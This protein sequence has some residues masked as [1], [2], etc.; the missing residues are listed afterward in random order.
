MQKIQKVSGHILIAL[1][2]IVSIMDYHACSMCCFSGLSASDL[3][4]HIKRTHRHDSNFIV[5]CSVENCAYSTKSWGAFKSHVSKKHNQPIS[6]AQSSDLH[7]DPGSEIDLCEVDMDVDDQVPVDPEHSQKLQAAAYM[8]KLESEKKVSQT[9]LNEIASCT[10]EYVQECVKHLKLEFK[11]KLEASLLDANIV[12][13]IDFETHLSNFTTQ[14]QREKFYT[15]HCRHIAPQK[16]FLGSKLERKNGKV[17]NIEYYGYIVKMSDLIQLLMEMPEMEEFLK[18]DQSNSGLMTDIFD[19]EYVKSHPALQDP[20]SLLVILSHDDLEIVNPLGTHVKKHKISMF[21]MTLGNIPPQFRSKLSSIFL[22]AVSKSKLL[23]EFGS[24]NLLSDFVHSINQMQSG[25][26]TLSV[27]GQNQVIKGTLV[28]A[29][30]DTPAA[31][32]LGGFKEGVSFAKKPCRTCN[33]DNKDLAKKLN[34]SDLYDRDPQTHVSRCQRLRQM[35]G[36]DKQW[37]SKMWGV[38]GNSPLLDIQ[39][40]DLPKILVHDPM[41]ILLEGIVPQELARA[42]YECIYEHKYFKLQ[43]L[44]DSI[45]SYPYSYLD[46]SHKPELIEKKHIVEDVKIKQTSSA[47]LTLTF[48]MPHVI[49]TKIPEGNEKYKNLLVLFQIVQLATCPYADLDTAAQINE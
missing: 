16:V 12:D 7:N 32:W 37:W 10:E 6:D 24:T 28:M 47:M 31:Q 38:N 36:K 49:G 39:N 14:Y 9:A 27:N 48:I 11:K 21:Y 41:H 1:I 43:W 29:V 42:L 18:R 34:P 4:N 30:C 2:W 13:D 44:N 35:T 26:M 40:L 23:R 8:L 25:E 22:L 17:T 5:N 46:M 20:G 15:E 19:G 45:K 33:I 3:T